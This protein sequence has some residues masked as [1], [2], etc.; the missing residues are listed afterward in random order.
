MT[1][2][3]NHRKEEIIT[4]ESLMPYGTHKGTAMANVPAAYLIWMYDNNKLIP[5]LKRYVKDNMEVL[6]QELK[7]NKPR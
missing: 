7:N 1:T 6:R 3:I 2:K 5:P 4:D